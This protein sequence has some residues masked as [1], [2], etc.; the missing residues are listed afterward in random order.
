MA[1]RAA[2]IST[3]SPVD[4]V[5]AVEAFL[6]IVPQELAEGNL[7]QLGDFGTFSL[8]IRST[9]ADT[10]AEVTA[11][12]VTNTLVGFRPGKRFKDTLDHITYEKA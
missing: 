6:T 2:E 1:D 3:L 11:R 7:V 8:R 10:A 5:A 4:I 9:G 12:N